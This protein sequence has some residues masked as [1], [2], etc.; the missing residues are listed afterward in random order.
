MGQSVK[1]YSFQDRLAMSTGIAANNEVAEIL[2]T[3]LPNIN[4]VEKG[5]LSDDKRG[6]DY[7]AYRNGLSPLGVDCK[8]RELDPIQEYGSDDL[9]LE[10]WS[11][12]GKKVGWTADLE[13]CCDYILWFFVPT[14]RWVLIPF[15]MLQSVF[16]A[17]KDTWLG[18]Y[19]HA[20]QSTDNGRWESECV[21]VPRL[22][23]WRAIYERFGGDYKLSK[24]G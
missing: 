20:R 24:G 4:V 10:I 9:A 14:K 23:I 12:I 11:V 16:L 13:K 6:V 3:C 1:D 17:N 19:R 15:P 5:Q 18:L 21:F 8:I 22:V 7:W 2:V